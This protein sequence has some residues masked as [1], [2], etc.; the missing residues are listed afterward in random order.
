MKSVSIKLKMPS[1][2]RILNKILLPTGYAIKRIIPRETDHV[3]KKLTKADV[4]RK[5]KI[6][7]WRIGWNH[8]RVAEENPDITREEL[9]EK[10]L[11]LRRNIYKKSA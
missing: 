5:Y 3:N 4:S 1:I 2:M 7:Y 9:I 10:E 6:P 11:E 8:V